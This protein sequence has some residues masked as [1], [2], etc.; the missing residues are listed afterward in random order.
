MALQPLIQMKPRPFVIEDYAMFIQ[1][2]QTNYGD[3][4]KKGTAQQKI[5]QL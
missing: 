5:K 2:L 4:D 3:L 1:Y